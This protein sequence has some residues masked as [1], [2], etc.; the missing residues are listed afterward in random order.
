MKVTVF[1]KK[2]IIFS[3]LN[4]IDIIVYAIIFLF[5]FS[6]I[7]KLLTYNDF[8]TQLQRSLPLLKLNFDANYPSIAYL[9]MNFLVVLFLTFP[10][11]HR[12]GLLMSLF[13]LAIASSYILAMMFIAEYLPCRCLGILPNI[14]WVG[15]LVFNAILLILII[16]PL[17][18]N[19][20]HSI[21]NKIT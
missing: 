4:L 3:R 18:F 12:V 16:L 17:L 13:C 10:E 9:A 21:A 5:A 6:F 15:H 2:R 11:S 19:K 14:G 1:K 20:T 8:T 7:S